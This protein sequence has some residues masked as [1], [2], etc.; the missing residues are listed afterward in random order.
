[1]KKDPYQWRRA[2]HI[3]TLIVLQIV[4][5]VLFAHFVIYDP[6]SAAG[7]GEAGLADGKE[8]IKVYPSKKMMT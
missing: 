4:F 2:F 6:H 5:I 7:N 3:P 8:A 1:M